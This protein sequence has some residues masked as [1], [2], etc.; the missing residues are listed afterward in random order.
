MTLIGNKADGQRMPTPGLLNSI[1]AGRDQYA[2]EFQEDWKATPIV[3][4]CNVCKGT[5]IDPNDLTIC[6]AC[7]GTGKHYEIHYGV[8]DGEGFAYV[9]QYGLDA[10]KEYCKA[11]RESEVESVRASKPMIE[12]FS[13]PAFI[14]I[15]WMAEGIP[16]DDLMYTDQGIRYLANLMVERYGQ[17]FMKTNL[18]SF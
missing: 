2:S 3:E 14:R 7:D 4:P 6:M 18:L 13:M 1:N 12:V 16:V 8:Q 17:T 9:T 15:D 11:C 10:L 5:K